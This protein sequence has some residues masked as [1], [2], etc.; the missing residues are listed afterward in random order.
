MSLETTERSGNT[1]L[2]ILGN[3][4][5]TRDVQR[6]VGVVVT[7]SGR[8]VFLVDLPYSHK[9]ELVVRMTSEEHSQE[10]LGVFLVRSAPWCLHTEVSS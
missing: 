3:V 5:D 6:T 9:H 10:F 8:E 1:Y 4:K 2:E 7:E